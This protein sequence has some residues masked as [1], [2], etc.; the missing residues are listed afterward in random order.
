MSF[1]L[2]HAAGFENPFSNPLSALRATSQF[3]INTVVSPLRTVPASVR[4][5]RLTVC[6]VA[7]SLL[8]RWEEAAK[9][10]RMA[11]KLD[12]DEQTDEWLREV[13][14]NVS[15]EPG[16]LQELLDSFISLMM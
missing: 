6:P 11:C 10:L 2:V 13:T 5:C 1:D 7:D 15:N 16:I 12:F 14:P 8:G 9:D 4:R 3:I